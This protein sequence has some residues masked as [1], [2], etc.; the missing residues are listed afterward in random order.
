M[1]TKGWALVAGALAILSAAVAGGEKG[2]GLRWKRTYADA[3]LEARVRN[4]PVL[5]TRQKDG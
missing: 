3:L 4:L 2:E 1:H 5:V